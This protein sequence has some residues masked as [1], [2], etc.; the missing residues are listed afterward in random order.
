MYQEQREF[1]INPNVQAKFNAGPSKNVLLVGAD[2][3][4]STDSGFMNTNFLGYFTGLLPEWNPLNPVFTTP[5]LNPALSPLFFPMFDFDTVYKTKGVYG[6][7]QTTLYDRVH[8]LG[9]LRW[10][11]IDVEYREAALFVP[12]TFTVDESKV[13][14]RAGIVVD[15]FPG[16]SA[17]ASYSEGM[18]WAGFNQAR[19]VKPEFSEQREAGLKFN[20]GQQL[21]GTMA[22]FDIDRSNIPVIAGGFVAGLTDQRARGFETDVIYQPNRNWQMLANYGY[23]DAEIVSGANAGNRLVEVPQHSG[24]VWF[25]YTFDPD[26]LKGWS[27]GAGIYAASSQFVDA[28]NVW[29]TNPYFTV[30]AKIGYENESFAATFNIKNLTGEEYFVPYAW[31]GGQVAPG[32]D[33]AFY[34]TLVYKY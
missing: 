22:V 28:T 9:G 34:G 18:R 10:A 24:R 6:Q 26:V 4:R 8:L 33:R 21:S 16:V 17:Y 1:T 12:Q 5:Y 32:A 27:V 20:F 23:T 19:D 31:F 7:L 29:S 15:L 2:Y 30:D 13:L 25:N 11:N 3:A 14:P